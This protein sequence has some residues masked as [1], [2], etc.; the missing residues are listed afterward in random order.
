MRRSAGYHGLRRRLT[1]PWQ[2]SAAARR[3]AR[4]RWR[5]DLNGAL[6]EITDGVMSGLER[7]FVRDVERP[8]G[9]PRPQR[10]A[11]HRPRDIS[12]YLDNYYPDQRLAVELDGLA[13]HPAETRWSDIHRDNRSARQGI[14]TLRY[15]WADIT[16]RSCLVAAE[17]AAVL[18]QRGWTGHLRRCPRCPASLAA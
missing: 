9:L 11:R 1:T 15:N 17:I 18:Q 10:Q 8:H 6:G 4:L 13:A 2:L 5:T 7:R 14:I 3:R 16:V 12:A